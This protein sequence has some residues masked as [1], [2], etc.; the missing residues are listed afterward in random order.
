MD[1]EYDDKEGK[2]EQEL[3]QQQHGGRLVR[4][5]RRRCCPIGYHY[6]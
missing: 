3:E 1:E 6:E 2:E 4:Q 5:I